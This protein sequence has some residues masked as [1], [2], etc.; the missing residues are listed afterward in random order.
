M[1]Q[2]KLYRLV[3]RGFTCEFPPVGAAKL[4]AD[5]K[6][7]LNEAKKEFLDLT[8]DSWGRDIGVER[9]SGAVLAWFEKW[10]GD[11]SFHSSSIAGNKT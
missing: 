2:G 10:F 5:V 7:G 4:A 1:S 3:D 9:N 8:E 11:A 6:A